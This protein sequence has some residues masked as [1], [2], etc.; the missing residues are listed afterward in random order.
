V[1]LARLSR[2]RNAVIHGADTEHEVLESVLGF[3]ESLEWLLIHEQLDA[4]AEQTGLLTAL[5]GIRVRLEQTRSRL[6]GGE[7]PDTAIFARAASAS[8]DDTTA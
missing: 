3:A 8:T 4:A 2:Q 7:P 6:L 1:L 5:S